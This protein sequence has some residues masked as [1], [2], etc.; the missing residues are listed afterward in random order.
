LARGLLA[1]WVE[2]QPQLRHHQ[3]LQFYHV[4]TTPNN[5][6]NKLATLRRPWLLGMALPK[7]TQGIVGAYPV[8][9]AT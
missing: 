8:A 3:V 7:K 2:R 1:E 4:L 5:Y 6:E 9:I